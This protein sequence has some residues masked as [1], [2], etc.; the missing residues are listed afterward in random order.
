MQWICHPCLESKREIQ[1]RS[2]TRLDK[3]LDLIPLVHTLTARIQSL[4]ERLTGE[5]LEVKIEEVVDRKLAEV[6]EEQ[7][8]PKQCLKRRKE[9]TLRR[10]KTC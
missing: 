3:L 1:A 7:K 6:M 4:E 10:L 8:A 5:S 9:M 2:D